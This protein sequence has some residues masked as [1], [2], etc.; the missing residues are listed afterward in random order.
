MKEILILI[1]NFKVKLNLFGDFVHLVAARFLQ[2]AQ[3]FLHSRVDGVVLLEVVL[4]R[5][6]VC[7]PF[8]SLQQLLKRIKMWIE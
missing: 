4:Y 6:E 5:G 8:G 3:Q 2:A 7:T 1:V